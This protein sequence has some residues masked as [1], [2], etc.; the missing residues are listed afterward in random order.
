MSNREA[1]LLLGRS[2]LSSHFGS[3]VDLCLLDTLA[4][5]VANEGYDFGAGFLGQLTDLDFRVL[6]ESLLN[7]TGFR[8]VLF[9]SLSRMRL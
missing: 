4:Y 1:I 9:R 2:Y 6:D 8:R 3:E 5:F 7:Q